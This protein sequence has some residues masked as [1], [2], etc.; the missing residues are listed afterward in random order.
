MCSKQVGGGDVRHVEG[1]VLA[2]QDHVGQRQV[3]PFRVA[4]GEMVA[5]PAA[6][7]ERPGMGQ[8][9]PMIEGQVLGQVVIDPVAPL[10]RLHRHDERAVGIDIDA[11]DGV[12]LNGNQERHEPALS[13]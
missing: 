4:D 12:H 1:R 7:L 10:L 11:V 2:H 5:V 9:P 8:H 3:D 6:Q 13:P